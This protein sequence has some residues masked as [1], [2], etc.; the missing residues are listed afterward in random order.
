MQSVAAL[1]QSEYSELSNDPHIA[2]VSIFEN[3]GIE[4]GVSNL[5]PHGQIYATDFVT[6]VAL[7]MRAAQSQYANENTG[8]SLLAELLQTAQQSELLIVEKNNHCTVLVPACAR[9]S[10]EVWI[11]PHRQLQSIDLMSDEERDEFALACQRQVR[12]YDAL[13]R[14]SA[15]NVTLLHNAPTDN[16]PDNAHWHFHLCFQP[17]LRDPKRMKYLAGFESGSGNI[18]NPLQPETAAAELRETAIST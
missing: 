13:F 11:V 8:K 9:F 1:W 16:H 15:P 14:R 10:Y 2:Q 17:P 3:K 6:D 5:H 4:I 7:R 18:I 12:R